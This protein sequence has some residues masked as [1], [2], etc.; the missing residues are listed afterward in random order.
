[1]RLLPDWKNVDVGS[2]KDIMRTPPLF[3]TKVLKVALHGYAGLT[4]SFLS[5]LL[6]SGKD[7]RKMCLFFVAYFNKTF[8]LGIEYIF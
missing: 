1:M 4:Y 2:N 3:K 7:R 6:I 8:N 5:E